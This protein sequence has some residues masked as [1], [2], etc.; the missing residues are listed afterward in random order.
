MNEELDNL[1]HESE[2]VSDEL[3]KLIELVPN[4]QKEKASAIISVVRE[5]MVAFSGPIPPPE[6]FG[7]YERI[8]P[9]SADRILRMAEKQQ[10]HRMEI[11]KEAVTKNL[12]HNKRGQSFGFIAMLLMLALSVLFVFNGMKV[13]AGIIGSVTIGTLVALFLSGNARNNKDLQSKK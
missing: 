2:N 13:W 5:S 4:E 6:Q 8:L 9:G 12:N 10:D 3:D 7:Q 1:S 11:E